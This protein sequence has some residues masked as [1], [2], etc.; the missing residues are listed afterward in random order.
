MT[1]TTSKVDPRITRTRKLLLDSFRGLLAEKEF[2][3]IT[4]QDIAARATV[5]RATFYAHFIDKYVMADEVMRED[6]TQRLEERMDTQALS[7]E[8]HV[9]HLLVVVCDYLRSLYTQCKHSPFFDSLAEA[10]IKAHLR[11]HVRS[12]ISTRN[13]APR[14]YSH[15]RF[16]V[17]ITIISWAIYGAA[18]EW[19]QRSRMQ[20]AEA[21]ANEVVPLIV[22]SLSAFEEPWLF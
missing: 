22:A 4:V 8:E 6:F 1:A 16:E 11:E 9:R 18:M 13:A 3:G 14:T 12:A 17:L 5:N 2:D 7:A 10:R 19:L 15:P 21:F 20:T